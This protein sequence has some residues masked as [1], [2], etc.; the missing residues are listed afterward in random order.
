MEDL[1]DLPPVERLLWYVEAALDE[2]EVVPQPSLVGTKAGQLAVIH[3]WVADGI[4]L[5]FLET[6]LLL[7]ARK[8]SLPVTSLRF[9]DTNIRR[10]WLEVCELAEDQIEDPDS[11]RSEYVD[12]HLD[13]LLDELRE[14]ALA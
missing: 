8:S 7:M 6:K 10:D 14:R 2:N 1:R 4:P 3:E 11:N 13:D 12:E 9:F 5:E